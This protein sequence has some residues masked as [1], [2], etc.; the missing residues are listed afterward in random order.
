MRYLLEYLVMFLLR[1]LV[2]KLELRITSRQDLDT[3]LN[4]IR[5]FT[6]SL[7]RISIK[8]SSEMKTGLLFQLLFPILKSKS[9]LGIGNEQQRGY[10]TSNK[11]VSQLCVL[12]QRFIFIKTNSLPQP[13]KTHQNVY[14]FL[15]AI[16]GSITKLK[17]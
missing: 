13:M 17:Q 8:I 15:L 12:Y 10:D 5:D 14:S 1:W 4:R 2:I 11:R 16:D 3:Q 9:L 7:S 6:G